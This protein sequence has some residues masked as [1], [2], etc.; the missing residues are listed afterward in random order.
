M[1]II[2]FDIETAP[3][4]GY[5]WTTYQ[6]DVLHEVR[7]SYLLCFAWKELNK[8]GTKVLSLADF[9]PNGKDNDGEKQLVTELW[10]I[11][12]D[13]DVVIAHNG[14]TFDCKKANAYFM[15]F[16]LKPP[17]PYVCVDTLREYKKVARN[18][19]HKLD[20]LGKDLHLG[21]KVHTGGFQ[22]W[23]DCM[24][25]HK[26]SKA[27]NH[28]TTYCKQ[29]VRLLEAIYNEILP[30][31]KA[32]PNLSVLMNRDACPRCGKSGVLVRRGVRTTSAGENPR[33][34]CKACGGWCS[35]K[36]EKDSFKPEYR[37][38]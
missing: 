33:Y 15:R 25:D 37:L 1:K 28:M 10:K 24:A 5:T 6:A 2:S 22:L 18:D 14:I 19:S 29:D 23:L 4:L 3:I 17:E 21:R 36:R 34:R 13:A 30:W 38:P 20:F 27:W 31:M 8:G 9:A 11:L 35:G 7:P 26:N 16:G 12:N 32:H